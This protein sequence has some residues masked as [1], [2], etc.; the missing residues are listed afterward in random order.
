MDPRKVSELRAFVKMCKQD[1]SILHTEE[2]RF[3]REWVERTVGGGKED[4]RRGAGLEQEEK[5]D[6]EKAEE[7]IQ[8]EEPSSEESDLE[9]DNEGVIEPD[10]DAPQE[11]GDENVEITEEMMDQ[12]N[13]KKVAAIEA[14]ND[15]EL[16]GHWEEAA[17]DLALISNHSWRQ[18]LMV[19]KSICVLGMK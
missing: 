15:G 6:S 4:G 10:T 7:N 3:L 12:A 8:T 9:I 19:H 2:M 1:P 16:L 14:L 18:N 17:H 13:D 5:T 11:M